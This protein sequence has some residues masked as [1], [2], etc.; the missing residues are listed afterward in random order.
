M[1]RPRAAC[2]SVSVDSGKRGVGTKPRQVQVLNQ[3][4]QLIYAPDFILS[5]KCDVSFIFVHSFIYVYQ[6]QSSRL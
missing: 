4:L 1:L 6:S 2:G 5:F 3:L